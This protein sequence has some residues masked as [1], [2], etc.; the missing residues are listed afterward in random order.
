MGIFK[1]IRRILF[2]ADVDA[3]F[4]EESKE[5]TAVAIAKSMM[6]KTRRITTQSMFDEEMRRMEQRA[7]RACNY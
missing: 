6:G 7:N 4:S 1:V 2:P 5:K 3:I